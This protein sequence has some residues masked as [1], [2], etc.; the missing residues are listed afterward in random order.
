MST[1]ETPA[2]VTRPAR[3][4][5]VA[6]S[7][8]PA[9]PSELADLAD[10]CLDDPPVLAEPP[11]GLLVPHAGLVFS[12]TIAGR[13]WGGLGLAWQAAGVEHDTVM[14]AGTNHFAGWID[15]LAVWDGGP[16]QT[17][18]GAVE[19]DGDLTARVIALGQG[20]SAQRSAHAEEHSIEVQLPLLQ[21]AAPGARIV[22]FL[23]ADASPRTLDAAQ[24]LGVLL[25]EVRVAGDPVVLVASTDFAHY[26]SARRSEEV[27]RR[28]LEPICALDE[29]ALGRE[30]ADLRRAGI[31]GL[32]CG[33]CGIDPSR[34]VL[35]A[36][37]AAGATRATVLAQGTSADVPWGDSE[38]TVGYAS[39]AFFA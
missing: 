28:L 24:R 14:I 20:I 29:A 13:A 22:P 33:M 39:V 5:A 25:A 10:A 6:G 16:W 38:R 9:R 12:G 2:G 4:A 34:A 17:P 7:F 26:P 32:A 1:R 18:L 23:V 31:P 8:Y 30:E 3:T 35:A 27:N 36:L 19:V 37:R 15:G 11:L 21:R